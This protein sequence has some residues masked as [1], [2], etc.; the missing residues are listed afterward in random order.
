MN[1]PPIAEATPTLSLR[2]ARDYLTTMRPYLLFV[3]GVT[4]LAGLA[5]APRLPAATTVALGL[6]FFLSYGF[7]QALTDCFQTDTDRLSSPYRPLVAGRLTSRQVMGVSLAGLGAVGALLLGVAPRTL[8][9]TLAAV[10]GLA[11]YTWCK[12][13]WWAGPAWNASVVVVLAWIAVL[14]G[15]GSLTRPVTWTLVLVFVGYANFVLAGYFKDVEADRTTGYRTLPVVFGL[16]VAARLSDL[17]ALLTVLAARMALRRVNGAPT[18]PA[19]AFFGLGAAAALVGQIRLH[20]VRRDDEAHRA[21]VWTVHTYLLL[22]SAIAAA[23][24]P[25]WTLALASTIAAYLLV[26]RARPAREQI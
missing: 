23:A 6:A 2:F 15:G 17:L 25:G 12:R 21:V 14:A 3:S 18:W 19:L 13:R 24:R 4:G 16:G 7:G 1:A 9:W 22:L 11:G 5:L 8:P 26:L 10:A 20:G